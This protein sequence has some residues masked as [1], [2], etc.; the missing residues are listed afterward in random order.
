PGRHNRSR[1]RRCPPD[2]PRP[3][4]RRSPAR[5]PGRRTQVAVSSGMRGRRPRLWF[6]EGGRGGGA[7]PAACRV[8]DLAL[9]GMWLRLPYRPPRGQ[10]LVARGLMLGTVTTWRPVSFITVTAVLE[11]GHAVRHSEAGRSDAGH[12]EAGKNK[13][14][15]A[16]VRACLSLLPS[17]P[18][19]ARR[20]A[21]AGVRFQVYGLTAPVDTPGAAWPR[22][23]LGR[24][25]ARRRRTGFRAQAGRSN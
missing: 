19:E 21:A 5:S 2:S 23:Q 7:F 13:G 8:P 24:V 18:G 6:R 16:P 3:W 9:T 20:V 11:G 4:A 12:S 14:T 1:G 10:R 22:V 25:P 15:P 17:G